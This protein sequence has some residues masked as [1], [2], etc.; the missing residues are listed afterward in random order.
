MIRG[1]C[2]AEHEPKKK[3][4]KK[5]TPEEQPYGAFLVMRLCPRN[6]CQNPT[7]VRVCV[8]VSA[9][10]KAERARKGIKSC[11]TQRDK[12][13]KVFVSA[14]LKPRVSAARERADCYVCLNLNC[15][16][17]PWRGSLRLISIGSSDGVGGSF[18]CA[19][20]LKSVQ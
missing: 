4:R 7:G 19:E 12:K 11:S 13:A 17:I 20:S 1:R 8:C 6:Q 2:R 5:T 10:L 16:V 3:K 14:A 15:S 18:E 9:C